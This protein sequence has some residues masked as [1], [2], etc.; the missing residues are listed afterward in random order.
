M[1]DFNK[2]KNTHTKYYVRI[3]SKQKDKK[4]PV[5]FV[6]TFHEVLSA[7]DFLSDCF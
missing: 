5:A 2:H 1:F 7:T 6:K 4:K 3:K